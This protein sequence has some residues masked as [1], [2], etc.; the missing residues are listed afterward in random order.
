MAEQLNKLSMYIEKHLVLLMLTQ[1][2]HLSS[3]IAVL[4]STKMPD[5]LTDAYTELHG[6]APSVSQFAILGQ[7]EKI[8]SELEELDQKTKV[9]FSSKEDL[10]ESELSLLK[11]YAKLQYE[12]GDYTG[13]ALALEELRRAGERNVFGELMTD[14]LLDKKPAAMNL[15][16][17]LQDEYETL[18]EKAW[19][20]HISLFAAFPET[21]NFFYKLTGLSTYM[22]TI[23]V[24]CPH[25]VRYVVSANLLC[26]PNTLVEFL[27]NYAHIVKSDPALGFL[28]EL[29]ST[30]NFE[31]VFELF[32]FFID[33]VKS[34]FFLEQISEKL[35]FAAKK[36]ITFTYLRLNLR[37]EA[38]WIQEHTHEDPKKVVDEIQNDY[39][40]HFQC[41]G[42]NYQKV[43]NRLP[44]HDKLQS[45]SEMI[46]NGQK[47]LNK[48]TKAFE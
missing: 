20:L 15:I 10:L 13:C 35:I 30:F 41:D 17:D 37:V 34:D 31:K 28:T 45:F 25:L 44:V 22:N 7:K 1:P 3:K 36:F 47:L 33:A 39:H 6:S 48:P 40:V 16:E 23:E 9:L 21:P 19:L 32:R 27:Q 42:K 8:L 11:E 18:K 43:Q 12:V 46:A 14:V 29:F 5:A 26:K 24:G 2:C 38:K 4:A